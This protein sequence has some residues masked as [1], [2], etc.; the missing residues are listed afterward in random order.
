MKFPACLLL[1][2]N[3]SELQKRNTSENLGKSGPKLL[4]VEL[5]YSHE[6]KGQKDFTFTC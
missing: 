2:E 3:S 1:S 6:L 4:K 5:A